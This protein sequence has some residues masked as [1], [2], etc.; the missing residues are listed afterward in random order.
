MRALGVAAARLQGRAGAAP[1]S[2]GGLS[3]QGADGENGALIPLGTDMSGNDVTVQ[4]D[5]PPGS[6][7]QVHLVLDVTGYFQ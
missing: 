2:G 1:G 4:V 3:G 6:T 7:G 5:M